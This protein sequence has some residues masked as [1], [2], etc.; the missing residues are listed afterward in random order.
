MSLP[1]ERRTRHVSIKILAV[2]LLV[3]ISVP[4][5]ASGTQFEASVA[6]EGRYLVKLHPSFFFTSAF[7]TE[8]GKAHSMCDVTGLLYFEL[9]VQVQYGVTGSLSAGAILPVGWTYQEEKERADPIH[10]LAV[11]ELWLTLQHRW[12]T[13]PFVSSS[14]LQV[15]IPLAK[16]RSWEDGLRIGDGQIDVYPAYHFD[17]FS[18]S[19]FWYIQAS[20]GY[21]Y[22]FEDED[23]EKPFDEVKL[24]AKGG[25]ELLR[26]L[27]MRFFVY[28]DLADF[29]NGKYADDNRS[30]FEREGSLHAFGYGVSFWPRPSFRMEFTTG[31]DWS[32][33][34]RY[35]G[36]EWRVGYA[37][38]F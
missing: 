15:K 6:P 35:R 34:N 25:Y 17:Y 10:R 24:Y 38:I 23:G 37:K 21:K 19:H 30:F 9:P 13:F 27:R 12:L 8:D 18:S 5:A 22:R 33:R 3:L 28:A 26:D 20:V 29:R 16:K 1:S 2:A 36:I 11:R 32:G 31:G 4:I 14:A 7:F